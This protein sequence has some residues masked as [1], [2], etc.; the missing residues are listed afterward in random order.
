MTDW[1]MSERGSAGPR[2]AARV[3]WVLFMVVALVAGCGE[4]AFDV[5][6]DA[7]YVLERVN[8]ERLPV[9]VGV[10]QSATQRLLADTIRF[11][12]ESRYEVTRWTSFQE[13][14]SNEV[15]LN[16]AVWTGLLVPADGGFAMTS[17]ACRDPSVLALCIPP[18]TANTEGGDL[19]V[20]GPVPPAGI[21]R[22]EER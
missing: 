8:G 6:P 11:I 17:D 1:R 15:V 22:Y 19:V 9:V 16:R 14:G 20:R 12:G 5:S 10:T 21:K 7:E 2:T 18:D 3:E 4:G 13:E